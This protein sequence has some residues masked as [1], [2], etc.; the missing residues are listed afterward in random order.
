LVSFS[1]KPG[2]TAGG[3]E[4]VLAVWGWW[5]SSCMM[6]CIKNRAKVAHSP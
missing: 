4:V 6:C 1:K 2:F 5:V 3:G